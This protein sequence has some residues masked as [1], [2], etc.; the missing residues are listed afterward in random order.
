MRKGSNGKPKRVRERTRSAVRRQ[1]AS[2]SA[3]G[4]AFDA[5]LA[6]LEAN[7]A[8]LEERILKIQAQLRRQRGV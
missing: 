5:V 4:D 7:A 8:E 1:S 6:K 2:A 3:A